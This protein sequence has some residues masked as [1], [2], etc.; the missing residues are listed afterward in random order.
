MA[1]LVPSNSPS[2]QDLMQNLEKYRLDPAALTRIQ[3]EYSN[4]GL[5]CQV[6]SVDPSNPFV[7]L[8]ERSAVNTAVATNAHIPTYRKLYPELAYYQEE[9]YHHMSDVDYLNRF[10]T[11]VETEFTIVVQSEDLMNKLVLDPVENCYKAILPRE[12][13]F[14]VDDLSY[15]LQ[16]PVVI[17]RFITGQVEISYDTSLT[18][19]LMS[20]TTNQIPLTLRKDPQQIVWAFFNV[21]VKQMEI[22]STN[23]VVQESSLFERTI[24][25]KDQYYFTRVFFRNGNT[26]DW[27][28]L[29][30][31]HSDLV[32][33]QNKPT[34]VLTVNEGNR[35]LTVYIPLIYVVSGQVSGQLRIDVYTTKGYISVSYKDY[36]PESFQT[37]LKAVDEQRDLS[38]FTTAFS[39]MSFYGYCDKVLEGGTNGKTLDQMRERV[40]F[41][42][43]GNKQK[44]IT[45]IDL[46]NDLEDDGFTLVPNV[47]VLTNRIFLAIRRLPYPSNTKLLTAANVGINTYFYNPSTVGY[48]KGTRINGLRTTILSNN[49]FLN[50]NGVI[51]LIDPD[52]FL[53]F[54][55][56]KLVI[57]HQTNQ[58]LYNPFHY[59]ID[60]SGKELEVRSYYLDQPKLEDLNFVSQ[61]QTLQAPVNTGSFSITK[62]EKGYRL[63]FVSRSGNNYKG[64][65]DGA[66]GIHIAFKPPGESKFAYI[67]A[68]LAGKTQAGERVYQVDMDTSYDVSNADQLEFINT[69]I[70]D[71]NPIETRSDLTTQLHVFYTTTSLTANYTP[72]AEDNMIAK[73]ILPRGS[74]CLTHETFKVTY[75]YAL[76]NLWTRSRNLP[77]TIRYKTYPEDIPLY[78]DRDIYE[79]DPVT[80]SI[81]K[82][83]NAGNP[84]YTILHHQRDPVMDGNGNPMYIHRKGDVM[85]N[86]TSPVVDGN[87]GTTQELDLLLIDG[88]YMFATDTFVA[89]YRQ[90]VAD[91][92]TSW[93]INYLAEKQKILLEKTKFFFYPTTTLGKIKIAG[94]GNMEEY[95]D[96][97]QSFSVDLMVTKAVY[98]DATL[99]ERIESLTV[100]VL[101]SFMN[102]PTVNIVEIENA[103]RE[104]YQSSVVSF[105]LSGLAG[106]NYAFVAVADGAKRLCLK[107]RLDLL[108]DN[109]IVI[110]ED[111]TF[112]YS[113][114]DK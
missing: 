61:N 53:A 70:F 10:A 11:P 88:K 47:D 17:R 30:T 114:V 93:V 67:Q 21:K 39:N 111:I 44:P 71:N 29:T 68:T 99:R 78:Y 107:K 19:P 36:K 32:Y 15:S 98:E 27:T 94:N 25:Y 16:Y 22:N 41:N 113:R 66:L 20:L 106:K 5:A 64:I 55:R 104:A 58:Y 63:V 85:F 90:N 95:V 57:H 31:T 49:L 14:L 110:K 3:F 35:T 4:Q 38:I 101:D 87:L 42:S 24:N 102:N 23:E 80:N 86:G 51:T 77:S 40:V 103:L 1:S 83:D 13:V 45:N 2:M 18:S 12:T 60:N 34:A 91:V 76:K 26:V 28:E 73:P 54:D 97:E 46:R 72:I 48:P 89:D 112:T 81:L 52:Y 82:F 92:L 7:S 33:D 9:L 65:N 8:M 62:T 79:V 100:K 56:Q 37:R 59:V 69:R 105:R 6:T 84:V 109:S 96:A 50:N 108:A 75:G 43:V 74:V